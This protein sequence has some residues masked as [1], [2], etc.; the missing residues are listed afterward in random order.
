MILFVHLFI[1]PLWSISLERKVPETSN[2][3]QIF[4]VAHVIDVSIFGQFKIKGQGHRG[5]ISKHPIPKGGVL[6]MAYVSPVRSWPPGRRRASVYKWEM[7]WTLG[8]VCGTDQGQRRWDVSQ[9][10]VFRH[11]TR[12]TDMRWHQCKLECTRFSD[13]RIRITAWLTL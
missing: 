7:V 12:R 4:S 3:A 9:S 10:V 8:V 6:W 2:L 11:T 1:Y 13:E 5:R